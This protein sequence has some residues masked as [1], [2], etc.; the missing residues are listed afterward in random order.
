[1]ILGEKKIGRETRLV[2][3][4][5]G[6]KGYFEEKEWKTGGGEDGDCEEVFY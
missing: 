6:D 5:K 3:E 1:M 4:G 2:L